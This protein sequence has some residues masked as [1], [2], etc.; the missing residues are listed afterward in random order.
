[1]G[2]IERVPFPLAGTN[3]TVEM[4]TDCGVSKL[5]M[6]LDGKFKVNCSPVKSQCKLI[7]SGDRGLL[8]VRCDEC[9]ETLFEVV[10]DEVEEDEFADYPYEEPGAEL[11][12]EEL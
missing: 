2:K 12:D 1:M 7:A 9:D 8:V 11:V 3:D 4:V 6:L 10:A 5:K